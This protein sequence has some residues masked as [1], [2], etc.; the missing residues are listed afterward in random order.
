[1]IA[2][3]VDEPAARAADGRTDARR[4][5]R[6]EGRDPRVDA[7][8]GG[9]WPGHRVR[10]V[11][12]G[13]GP[14]PRRRASSSWRAAG[15]PRTVAAAD[16]TDDALASAAS[17]MPDE[18]AEVPMHAPSRRAASRIASLVHPPAR[19]HRAR[20]PRRS[21]SRCLSPEFL[22][23][24]NLSILVKHVA[25][26]AILAIGMTFVILSGGI[27]LSVGSIAGL[28]GMVAGY[29]LSRGLTLPAAGRRRS[30]FTRLARRG[31]RARGRHG[32]SARSMAGWSRGC[33]SRRSSRRWACSTSRAAP[34]C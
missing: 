22:T 21:S 34:R 6:R 20:R 14:A 13:R 7:A 33:A 5:R 18:T 31:D 27:D 2:R 1:M 4:G 29:L 3:A 11:G 23:T 9:R 19:P 10:V 8:P 28:C 25:I 32:C 15:S 26:N 24:G 12:P 16:A 17:A 30:I